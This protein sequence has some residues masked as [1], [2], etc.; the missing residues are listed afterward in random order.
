MVPGKPDLDQLRR[1]AKDL[2][3]AAKQG[4][5]SASRRILTVSPR[6]TLA[7]AQLAIARELGFSSWPK[8]K[9]AL[10]L[11][12]PIV[13]RF[14]AWIAEGPGDLQTINLGEVFLDEFG[15]ESEIEYH[16]GTCDGCGAR[17]EFE[18]RIIRGFADH[19]EAFCPRCTQSLGTF[20]EDVGI[21]IPVRIVTE[22]AL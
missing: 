10:E 11:A 21:T 2:L 1:Q 13:E 4:D 3:R 12:H 20:R 16:R 8:L 19:I 7:S 17:F 18:T 6:Q 5:T 22:R 9:A 14:P 15:N